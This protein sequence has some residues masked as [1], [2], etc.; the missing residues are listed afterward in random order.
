MVIY[1]EVCAHVIACIEKT[2]EYN[3][4]FSVEYIR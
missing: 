3:A 4:Q 2:A 1:V